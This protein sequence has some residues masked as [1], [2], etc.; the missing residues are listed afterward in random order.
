MRGRLDIFQQFRVPQKRVVIVEAK[1]DSCVFRSFR[2][3]Q[4][5]HVVYPKPSGPLRWRLDVIEQLSEVREPLRCAVDSA[6]WKY[7]VLSV[8]FSEKLK[9]PFPK[10]RPR[11]DG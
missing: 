11:G 4:F 8:S 1:R 9:V 6:A 7:K 2:P 10:R 5:R 3:W